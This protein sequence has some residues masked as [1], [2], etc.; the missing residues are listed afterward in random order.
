MKKRILTLLLGLALLAGL[1]VPALAAGVT[2]RCVSPADDLGVV[3][4]YGDAPRWSLRS[5]R[6]PEPWWRAP[7]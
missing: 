5:P 6:M 2:V 4:V 7:R 3:Q 1:T